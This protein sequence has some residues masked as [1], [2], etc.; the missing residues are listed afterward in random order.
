LALLLLAL[1]SSYSCRTFATFTVHRSHRSPF[2]VHR[3]PFSSFPTRFFNVSVC[4]FSICVDS[5]RNV[6]ALG[7]AVFLP[8]LRQLQSNVLYMCLTM[9][10]SISFSLPALPHCFSSTFA[11]YWSGFVTVILLVPRFAPCY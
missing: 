2:T 1:R 5:T 8:L 6:P 11:V 7:F 4:Y 3:S 10:H 9:D